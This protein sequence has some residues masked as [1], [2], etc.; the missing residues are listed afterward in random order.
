MYLRAWLSQLKLQFRQGL[1]IV[2][3]QRGAVFRNAVVIGK[4]QL[5]EQGRHFAEFAVQASHGR[6]TWLT[7]AEIGHSA[8]L[9]DTISI[10][11][12]DQSGLSHSKGL[13]GVHGIH[14]T[15]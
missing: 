11:A 1:A 13:S 7:K 14:D 9:C 5:T 3:V 12:V 2:L 4:T 10:R 8:K 15:S 6:G